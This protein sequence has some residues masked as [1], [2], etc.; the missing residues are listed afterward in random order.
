MRPIL[1]WSGDTAL[2]PNNDAAINKDED[3]KT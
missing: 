1:F 2:N 3:S